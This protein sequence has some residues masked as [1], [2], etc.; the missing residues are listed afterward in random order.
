MCLSDSIFTVKQPWLLRYDIHLHIVT[1]EANSA[2][3]DR[4]ISLFSSSKTNLNVL[5][6]PNTK[7]IS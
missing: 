4:Q 6:I 2:H 1:C 3:G 7:N 5:Y